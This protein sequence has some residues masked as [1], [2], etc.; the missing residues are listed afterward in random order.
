MKTSNNIFR[1]LFVVLALVWAV[2][3]VVY[4][5]NHCLWAALASYAISRLFTIE[6]IKNRD[7]IKGNTRHSRSAGVHRPV[8]PDNNGSGV[9][10]CPNH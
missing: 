6:S 4:A 5:K 3:F 2:G 9:Y 10:R 7:H 1:L 8:L